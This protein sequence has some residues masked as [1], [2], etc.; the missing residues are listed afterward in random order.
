[1]TVAGLLSAIQD[2][3][4]DL[5]RGGYSR[6]AYTRAELELREW[7][8]AEASAR[9]LD[10][11]TDRNG[12]LWGWRPGPGGSMSGAV[13][14]GSHLDSVPGGGA[15]DGPLGIASALTAL[16]LLDARGRTATRPLALVVFPEEEGGRFG[17]ACLGSQLLTGALA[18]EHAL[19]LRDTDGTTLADALSVAG[20]DPQYIGRDEE[21]LGRIGTFVELHLEQGRGLAVVNQPVAIGA[22][23]IGHGLWRLIVTGEANH[24]GA[25]RMSDRRD[26]VVVAAA[27][28]IAVR[29]AARSVPGARATVGRLQVVPGGTNVIAS[30]VEI[31]LDVRHHHD[32]I[33]RSLVA[34]ILDEAWI[35]A[36]EEGCD[37]TLV[38]KSYGD[39]VGLDGALRERLG[40]VLPSAPQLDAGAGHDAGVLAGVVPTAMLFTRNPTGVSHAPGEAIEDADGERG[41]EALADVL[42]DLLT[43]P[44]L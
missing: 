9:G 37:L 5:R 7:F 17:Q 18:P 23:I 13:V 4:R 24:A 16:D 6:F 15:Y 14:T 33:A 28:V 30:R 41:A 19:R 1:M 11:H 35:A 36:A 10:V 39:A 32:D 20:V 26:P 2:V 44:S 27:V 31:W 25:T 8:S 22:S 38:E 29:N 34:T 40:A 43:G 12:L 3:G 21:T 42:Q